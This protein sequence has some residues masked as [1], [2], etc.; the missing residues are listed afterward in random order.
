ME[1]VGRSAEFDHLAE[2]VQNRRLV[3]VIGPGG[4]GKTTL[5]RAVAVDTA[6]QFE[7]GLRTIDLTGTSSAADV[8]H[9]IAGQ[10]GFPSF[11]ALLESPVEQPVLL[12][13]D[14]C[15]H[16]VDGA[17][18]AVAELLEHCTTPTVLATSRSPLDLPGEALV[19]LGPLGL[20]SPGIADHD[21]ASMQLFLARASDTG[22]LVE[23]EDLELVAEMCR[24]LDG[25]PL[26]LDLA[27]ARTRSMTLVEMLDRFDDHLAVL[28]RPR[29]RGAAR[30]RS[31]RATI[32]WSYDLLA[33]ADQAFFDQL[34]V[35][36]GLFTAVMAHAIAGEVDGD[37]GETQSRLDMLIDA[38]L[39][40]AE[41]RG[42][43]T[44]YRMLVSLRSLANE[45][46]DARGLLDQTRER[47]VDHA[48]A[49]ALAIIEASRLAW[50]AEL[51]LNLLASYENLAAATR[52]CLSNDDD[53]DRAFLLVTVMWGVIHQTHTAEIEALGSKVLHRWPD[54]SRP[55]WADAAATVATARYILGRLAEAEELA[56]QALD[57][58]ERSQLASVSL[59]RALGQI[60]QA[61]GD[62]RGALQWLQDAAALGRD[63][64]LDALARESEV[65]QAALL[66]DI[67]RVDEALDQIRF[68]AADAEKVGSDISWIWART[69][70]AYVQLRVNPREAI[71]AA[72]VCLADARVLGY[73]AGITSNLRSLALAHLLLDDVHG[74]I[75]PALDL[76]DEATMR[77]ALDETHSS[78][79]VAAAVLATVAGVSGDGAASRQFRTAAND[80]AESVRHL[81]VVSLLSS[82][83]HEL[84]PLSEEPGRRLPTREAVTLART[85]LRQISTNPDAHLGGESVGS[86]DKGELRD[87]ESTANEAVFVRAGDLWDLRFGGRTALLRHTKGMD[88]LVRLLEAAGR[89]MHCLD[90]VGAGVTEASSGEILDT[91]ARRQYED[92]IRELQGEIE[93]AEAFN[94][95][96]RA[97]GA[98]AELSRLVDELSSALGLGGK[99]RSATD[100]AERA[101]SSVTQRIR[102]AI[103]RIEHAIPPLGR[104]LD[105]SIGTGTFC[106]YQPEHTTEWVTASD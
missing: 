75:G 19:V 22:T 78:L 58:A 87:D 11:G 36:G 65:F 62:T 2:R 46:L 85:T 16:V 55:R 105:A 25:V 81:P 79:S 93:E 106:R 84:I 5:A 59:R 21:A 73:P 80:L 23:G 98:N 26:A 52:W 95:Q 89:E 39:L 44:W 48:V 49:Q 88:D 45:H 17:A 20:P 67:G 101:R 86:T 100:S 51:L 7:L 38:S 66:A 60:R 56:L 28:S 30:H 83:G 50:P 15:E 64:S 90:L 71:E 27:A 29:F 104:H 41:A 24:R 103:R 42:P 54:R 31:L 6:P 76:I 61:N 53:G 13:I 1:L 102:S 12:M 68:V 10:L 92:R 33:P 14:N 97:D 63:L 40:V 4:I 18:S 35:F 72:R 43:T 47:L 91:T 9:A 82:A 32:E 96:G 69:A 8:E 37:L 99:S 34:G 74:A 94:D 57:Q 70:E 3:T 77:G